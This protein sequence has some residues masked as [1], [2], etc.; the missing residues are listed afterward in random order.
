LAVTNYDTINGRVVGENTNG[1]QT[2]YMRDA[3]GSVTGT[4]VAGVV[5]NMY[6]YKRF[7]GLLTKTGTAADPKFQWNGG[8][9]YRATQRL[10]LPF[11]STDLPET[12]MD[13]GCPRAPYEGPPPYGVSDT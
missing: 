9:G 4:T 10:H 1:I 2:D 11:L 3:L 6:G 8:S 12:G 5:Q 13:C 7:G